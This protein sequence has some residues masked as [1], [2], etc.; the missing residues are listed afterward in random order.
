[1]RLGKLNGTESHRGTNMKQSTR[2]R[3]LGIVWMWGLVSA[4]V[5]IVQVNA[6]A[7]QILNVTG[8]GTWGSGAPTSTWTSPSATWQFS[9]QVSTSPI[10]GG[11]G[12]GSPFGP[13]GSGGFDVY[14]C[15]FSYSLNGASVS[16]SP[17]YI[18]FY[19][20]S[21][22]GGL[23]LDDFAGQNNGFVLV[24]GTQLFTGDPTSNPVIV[25]GTFDATGSNFDFTNGSR[26]VVAGGSITLG[27]A[28]GSAPEPGS[29]PLVTIA[30]AAVGCLFVKLRRPKST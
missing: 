15:N 25:T 4:A 1:V 20:T 19:S 18:E 7:A 16:T 24:P 8:N 3:Y 28:P 22:G 26:T 9:V 11:T 6:S 12:C 10:S 27:S 29:L 21:S 23:L 13:P 5:C 17:S 2:K 14:F 30:L